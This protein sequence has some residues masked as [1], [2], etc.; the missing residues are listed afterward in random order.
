MERKIVWTEALRPGLVLGGISIAYTV[1]NMLL[2]KL[3]GGT[4]V[5]VLVNV[6]GVIL[7]LAKFWLCISLFKAFMQKFAG[8]H[9]EA[10]NS[11]TFRFGLAAAILSALLYS[12]FYLA[13]VTLIA[14]EMLTQSVDIAREAYSEVLPADQLDALDELVPKLP[15]MTFFANL[16]YC[17]LFGTVLSAI[18]SRNI[19]S[20]NPFTES[21]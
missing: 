7:W 4:A 3:Q 13:L 16:I 2:A 14:P 19:P 12:A 21:E 17:T 6:S 8:A 15:A 18:F 20:R 11:D 10:G 5:S 9:Q 1:I